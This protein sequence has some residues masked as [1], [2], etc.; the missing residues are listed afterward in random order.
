MKKLPTII[1]Q[2]MQFVPREALVGHLRFVASRDGHYNYIFNE[3]TG[4]FA[5]CGRTVDE[6][7]TY[8]PFGAELCDMEIS[9]VCNGIN[10]VPCKHCYKS[11][12]AVGKN[13]PFETFKTIFHKIPPNLT[14]IAFGI[15][16]IDGNPDLWRI[17][18]YCRN[19]SY[20]KV[21]P[22][23][24]ING[25]NLTDAYA[26]Q[27][28]KVCGAIAVSHYDDDVCFDAVKKLTDTGMKQVNIHQLVAEETFEDCMRLLNHT[29]TD[30]RLVKLNAIVFLALK[31]KGRG[32]HFHPLAMDKY[33]QLI[34]FGLNH[35]VSI[36]CD[37]CSALRFFT[38]TEGHPDFNAFQTVVEPCESSLFSIYI[39]VN[40]DVYPCSFTEG[41]KIGAMDWTTGL[42]VVEATDFLHDI[43][44]HPRLI[45]FRE[46]LTKTADTNKFQCRS[47]PAFKV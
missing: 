8:S 44:L 35:H 39:N 33:K 24:T 1:L 40:G 21:A 4:F 47:C 31:Q 43:W 10:G 18:E 46:L 17:M 5:R 15:G 20:N 34:H 37:S 45:Q 27:F 13:M 25:W 9:T 23:I 38:S 16:D 41:E 19:N 12:T 26:E 30:P 2:L 14:Q 42:S 6:N 28:R 11:N 22:N 7:P 29:K 3:D 32:Q 36:G